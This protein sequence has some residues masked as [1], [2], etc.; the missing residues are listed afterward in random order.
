MKN[1]QGRV[2]N[3]AGTKGLGG[4]QWNEQGNWRVKPPSPVNSN[5]DFSDLNQPH[6]DFQLLNIDLSSR[7]CSGANVW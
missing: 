4:P 5:P 6:G 1:E 3:T 2:S 7:F